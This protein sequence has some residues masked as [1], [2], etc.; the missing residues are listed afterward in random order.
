MPSSD[1]PAVETNFS[2]EID[3]CTGTF[4]RKFL[5]TLQKYVRENSQIAKKEENYK[6]CMKLFIRI[7]S[8]VYMDINHIFKI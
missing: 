7:Y 4:I 3:I 6:I 8:Y 5:K 2:L 1:I